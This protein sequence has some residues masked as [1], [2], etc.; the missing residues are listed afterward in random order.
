M[1]TAPNV[2]YSSIVNSRYLERV[3]RRR[4]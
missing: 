1:Y 4:G 3:K 2:G